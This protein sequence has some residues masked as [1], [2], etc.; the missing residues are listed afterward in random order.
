MLNR[1]V[2]IGRLTDSPELRYTPNGVAIAKFTLAVE[3]SYKDATGNRETDFIDCT[4]WRKLAELIAEKLGKGRLV[5]VAGRLQQDRWTNEQGQKRSKL[6][7]LAD[8]IQF[9][10]WPKEQAQQSDPKDV[11]GFYDDDELPF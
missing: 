5:A 9:L 8:E 4:A 1:V 11:D 10:D 2:L 3:R 7:V 6:S